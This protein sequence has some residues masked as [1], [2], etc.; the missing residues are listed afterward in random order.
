MAKGS[1]PNAKRQLRRRTVNYGDDDSYFR[2]DDI[3]PYVLYNLPIKVSRSFK[4]I[5]A[6]KEINAP[7]KSTHAPTVLFKPSTD[8]IMPR[9]TTMREDPLS[10]DKYLPFHRVMT[11]RETSMN[12][13]DKSKILS[14]MDGLQTQKSQLLNNNWASVLPTI[15]RI[16]DP[17]D[18]NELIEKRK[19][20]V[21]EID[22]RLQKFQTWKR[23][24]EELKQE[25]K[26]YK[27]GL[28]R[29][30]EDKEYNI[31]LSELKARRKKERLETYGG[32][33]KLAL[34]NGYSLIID[35]FAPPKLIE[36]EEYVPPAKDDVPSSSPEYEEKGRSR[37]KVAK[38]SEKGGEET[39][40][41]E[42]R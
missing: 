10:D 14:E 2:F 41:E 23:R 1:D 42:Q 34:N 32:V 8:S 7:Q 21:A 37:R 19:L 30:S 9:K 38:R 28:P 3:N 24:Q 36:E 20:T 27:H 35:P 26:H 4:N 17:G 13:L 39:E 22:R 25:I 15:T 6:S 11:K 5:E 29:D 12:N 33:I 16:N 18:E 31:P 40:I